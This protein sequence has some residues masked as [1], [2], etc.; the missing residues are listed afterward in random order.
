ML[1]CGAEGP[2]LRKDRDAV[3]LITAGWEQKARFL[4]IPVERLGDD[5]F[6]LKSRVAGEILQKFVQYRVR[7]AI[8]GDISRY[9]EESSSLRDFVYESN[10]GEHVWFVANA[11]EL[12]Q[13]L[14]RR[15][16]EA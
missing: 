3:D 5:F 12:G 13:R 9:L 14:E 1:E 10:R 8:A 15:A 4:V 7:V 16:H 6:R 2:K 11:D